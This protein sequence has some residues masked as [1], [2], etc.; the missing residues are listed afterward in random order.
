[1]RSVK[2]GDRVAIEPGRTCGHCKHCRS[3]RYNLCAK[4]D[5]AATPPNDG[6][7][8]T[9]YVVP[10]EY[11]FRLPKSVSFSEGALLEPLSVAVH[12][13]RL[14]GNLQGKSTVIFGA[15]P[16]GLLCGAVSVAFGA[17]K[18]VL[19]DIDDTR[20][21]FAKRFCASVC[22]KMGQQAAES[23]AQEICEK[24]DLV[25]GAD[26]VVDAT[27]AQPCIECGVTCLTRGGTFIQAGLGA[28]KIQ[29]PIGQACD[30]E[31]VFKG[32]FRYGPGDYELA[33]ELLK[34]ERVKVKDLIT[35]EF[36]FEE[37]EAAFELVAARGG[38]KTII[39]GPGLRLEDC[40]L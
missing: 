4:V 11:C 15:G 27:G 1:M 26:V 23:N 5:F 24:A 22:F 21:D 10:E 31:I 7:L 34:S 8:A 3:G 39:Y 38:I 18:A 25:D 37:A 30:K 12:V 32:S 35:G 17:S 20:L 29:F 16:I 2:P 9:Y 19:V 33:L 6:T 14:A 28:P 36:P 13:C 40:K